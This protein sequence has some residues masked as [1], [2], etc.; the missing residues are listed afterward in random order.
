M[1]SSKICRLF[2]PNKVEVYYLLNIYFLNKLFLGKN[3][4]EPAI[5]FKKRKRDIVR[6][7][8][9]LDGCWGCKSWKKYG[10]PETPET[11]DGEY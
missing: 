6:Y 4:H 10:H 3:C 8:I 7:M 5:K 2:R 9:N 11:S 1:N